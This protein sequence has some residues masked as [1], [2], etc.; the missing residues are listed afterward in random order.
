VHKL[1]EIGCLGA[2]CVLVA[3]ACGCISGRVSQLQ[4]APDGKYVAYLWTD[5]LYGVHPLPPRACAGCLTPALRQTVSVRWTQV[6]EHACAHSVDVYTLGYRDCCGEE[7]EREV[8]LSIAPDS[9]II[10]VVTALALIRIDPATGAV[11]RTAPQQE[12]EPVNLMLSLSS[13]TANRAASAR[14]PD[15]L[16][17][18]RVN[19]LGQV[20]LRHQ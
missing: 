1:G 11:S 18:A 17:E 3:A 15:G 14:S 6:T 7:A 4:F 10:E 12:L 16:W 9:G 13:K 8:G 19:G 5:G 20:E 2:A